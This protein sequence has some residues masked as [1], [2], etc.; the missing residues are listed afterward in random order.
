MGVADKLPA[1][2]AVGY[3]PF[4]GRRGGRAGRDSAGTADFAG[5]RLAVDVA[6]VE[7]AGAED[8]AA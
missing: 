6:L 1:A 7:L 4:P 5:G 2:Y 8:L 3:G